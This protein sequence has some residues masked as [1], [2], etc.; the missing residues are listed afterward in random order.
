MLQEPAGAK[1]IMEGWIWADTGVTTIAWDSYSPGALTALK[2]RHK[3]RA[4]HRIFGH[5]R[6]PPRAG[7]A[8]VRLGAAEGAGQRLTLLQC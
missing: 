5:Q 8:P 2:H 1:D 3:T 6:A 4:P 7:D